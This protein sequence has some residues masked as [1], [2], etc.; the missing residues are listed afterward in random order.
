[1]KRFGVSLEDNLLKE[2]DSLVE[3]HQL[4]N[5]SQAIRFLIR[6]NQIQDKWKG[7]EE[8]SGCIVLVY[9][10]HKRD[11]INKSMHIQHDY[12]NSVLA[13]QHVHLDHHNCLETIAV[14]GKAKK[15]QELAD[16]LISLKGMKHGELVMSTVG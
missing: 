9:D 3:K 8:V 15:L 7:N 6:R 11:I 14:K 13:V 5:R 4:P 12:P 10:H 16:R 2:L 1:M